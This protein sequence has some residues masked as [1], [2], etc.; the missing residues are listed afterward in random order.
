MAQSWSDVQEVMG[1]FGTFVYDCLL[2]LH[3]IFLANRLM[4]VIKMVIVTPE[5]RFTEAQRINVHAERRLIDSMGFRE[6]F[7]E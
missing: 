3:Y 6:M 1:W 2:Q 4:C 5:K 7:R